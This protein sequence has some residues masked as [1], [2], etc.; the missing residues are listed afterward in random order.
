MRLSRFAT[1]AA[2]AL[3]AC[4]AEDTVLGRSGTSQTTAEITDAPFPY[5]SVTRVDL[6]VVSIAVRAN[7]PNGC[8]V[9]AWVKLMLSAASASRQGVRAFGSPA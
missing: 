4:Y 9:T 8:G 3:T 2:L 5:D 7:G 6:Y 1:C